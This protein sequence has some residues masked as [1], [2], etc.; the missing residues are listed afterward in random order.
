MPDWMLLFKMLFMNGKSKKITNQDIRVTN[1][2]PQTQI[3]NLGTNMDSQ[4]GEQNSNID[5]Q[6]VTQSER[7]NLNKESNRDKQQGKQADD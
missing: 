4:Q 5:S 6:Q 2:D 1:K 3:E 7:T